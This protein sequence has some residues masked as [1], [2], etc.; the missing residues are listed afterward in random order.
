MLRPVLFCQLSCCLLCAVCVQQPQPQPPL[1]RMRLQFPVRVEELL[2]VMEAVVA[3][4]VVVEY[5][6]TAVVRASPS[7]SHPGEEMMLHVR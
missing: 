3:A 2:S 7:S 6:Q 5:A 1:Q 4:V